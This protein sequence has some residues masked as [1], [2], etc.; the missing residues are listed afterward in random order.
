MKICIITPEAFPVP[1]VK[2]GAV[3]TL[4]T[5]LLEENSKKKKCEIT[6]VSVEDKEAENASKKIENTDF[7]FIKYGQSFIN[8][9]S[10]KVY[11]RLYGKLFKKN[12]SCIY[13][14]KK[15][16]RQLKNEKF[17]VV[18]IEGGDLE[19]YNYLKNKL[20]TDKFIAHSHGDWPG[21][22]KLRDLYD[23]HIV[24]SQYA[25]NNL[26][27]SD[28]IKEE[29]ISILENC[30]SEGF[31]QCKISQEEKLQIRNS[32]GIKPKDIVI[33]F[34]G[35]IN[36]DKGVREL[37]EAFL[38]MKYKEKCKLLIVGKANFGHSSSLTPFE[39][40]IKGIAEKASDRI[41]FTGF[42]HNT[43][44]P[45]IHGISDIAV[46]PSMWNEPSGMVVIEA[47]ASGLPIVATNSGGIPEL[48]SKE[49]GFLIDRD[50][51]VVENI[52]KYLDCLVQSKELRDSMGK[53]GKRKAE[54]YRKEQYY[55]NFV[56]IL[57][58]IK[59]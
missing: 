28:F 29:K 14:Q 45:E 38:K 39:E 35:R 22:K 8:E 49:C 34:C 33:M 37:L 57:E 43:K 36:A 52:A 30:I 50:E 6:M 17:D 55:N 18:I 10:R 25:K 11:F 26:I 4:V 21:S 13:Y 51:A 5:F 44:L 46:I 56:K 31:Y 23:H 16:Q 3:E 27:Q 40:E 54:Y 59:A 1:A 42:I 19:A 47:M 48:L 58:E 2:G 41:I 12:A 7:I 9:I 32:Y 53:E 15:I 20:C 24:I